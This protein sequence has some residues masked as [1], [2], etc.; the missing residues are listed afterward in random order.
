M[1]VLLQTIKHT[2]NSG[3]GKSKNDALVH[4]ERH[5]ADAIESLL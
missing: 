5:L 1:K 3:E 2:S 4:R